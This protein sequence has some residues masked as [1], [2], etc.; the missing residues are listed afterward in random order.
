MPEYPDMEL[1]RSAIA[2]RVDGGTL[3]A[4]RIGAPQVLASVEPAPSA[5][6]GRDVAGVQ[7]IGK[8]LVMGFS[9]G[10][11]CA[12]HLA[13]A[14]RFHWTPGP[15]GSIRVSPRGN[16]AVW[17][18][19][20]GP[21]GGGSLRLVERSRKK[22]ASI[23]VGRGPAFLR[24]LDRGGLEI[25]GS[26]PAAFAA[27][28]AGSTRTL[29]R[30]LTEPAR[31]AGIGNAWSDE[32]LHRARLSP[33]KRAGSLAPEEV[34]RLHAAAEEVLT[35]WAAKLIAACGEKFP[36][37]VTAFREGMAVHGRY[38]K[39]CPVCGAPVQRV[40]RAENEYN[41]CPTCQTGGKL[42]RDRA[43][44]R[45]LRGNWPR[46]LRE[47]EERRRRLGDAPVTEP[48]PQGSEM[49]RRSGPGSTR[50]RVRP[51]AASGP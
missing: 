34:A 2:A 20:G 5:L 26:D 4:F 43:M 1:Y 13:V 6:P 9:E 15:A 37:G 36:T 50:R 17:T 47:A 49:P 51:P 44:S 21:K 28:L 40:V 18:F 23:R 19:E 7:R 16:L 31:F 10:F 14:G 33:L 48:P 38:G 45:L 24:E 35:G 12:V 22:R 27:R 42:L 39:P 41:Y 8:Q 29:K 30:A 25:P 46:T 11:H 3:A 32:I